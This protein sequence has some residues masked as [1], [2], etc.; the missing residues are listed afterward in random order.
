MAPQPGKRFGRYELMSRL[1]YGGMAETWLARLLGEAGFSKAAVIKKVLPEYSD[2]YVFTSMLIS[3]ARI[4]ATLTHDN[5][6][7]VFDFGRVDNEY[8]LAMEYVDG[9]PLHDLIHRTLQAGWPSLP[10]PPAVFIGVAICRGLHY[11]HTRK[12]ETGKPLG[13]VHRDISPENV[14]ISYEGQVKII[15]LG[16]AKARQLSELA[17]EPGVVKGKYLFFSPE[18]ARGEE[19]DSRTDVWATG[20]TLY[21]LVCGKL[22]AEG[23]EFVVLPK[24][25]KGEFPRPRELNPKVP[26]R[27]E[28]ILMAALAVRKEDRYASAQEFGDAL[29]GF[30]LSFAPQF[31]SMTLSHYVQHLCRDTLTRQ[32]REVHVPRSFQDV[33]ASWREALK[34]VPVDENAA[35]VDEEEEEPLKKAKSAPVEEEEAPVEEEEAPAEEETS[36]E[37][38]EA[39]AEEEDSPLDDPTM[40]VARRVRPSPHATSTLPPTL[41]P[42]SPS[43]ASA[44]ATFA[45]ERYRSQEPQVAPAPSP[46]PWAVWNWS[47]AGGT[48][49]GWVAIGLLVLLLKKPEPEPVVVQAPPKEEAPVKASAG[50]GLRGTKPSGSSEEYDRFIQQAK[51][52]TGSRRYQ[53]AQDYYRAALKIRPDSVEAK[54]GLG[55]SLVLGNTGKESNEQAAKLLQEVVTEDILN[56]RAWFSLGMALQGLQRE[57]EAVEAY[58]KYLLLEPSGR[59]ASDARIALKQL[60][61]D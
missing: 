8:F 14:L 2:D 38:E 39:P 9:P 45:R 4:S 3:E 5:I 7:Q 49:V 10:L 36:A 12:D 21:E 11:A 61:A 58:K 33:L 55:F 43:S 24:M 27:L 13:I 16:L 56:A 6:A 34:V 1:G 57:D 54:E 28:D 40:P 31:T 42:A 19:V 47:I 41:P 52:A 20:I 46:S 35:P 60:D 29:A 15:D 48:A 59:F 23:P 30:L 25:G 37:E 17:T 26:R 18:Q 22:P 32:G 50:T 53:A 51:T 44:S